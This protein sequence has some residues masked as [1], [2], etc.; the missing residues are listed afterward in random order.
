MKPIAE[1]TVAT[2][3][4]LYSAFMIVAALATRAN[5]TPMIEAMIEMPPIASG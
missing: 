2:S 3:T 5:W 4:A 1:S